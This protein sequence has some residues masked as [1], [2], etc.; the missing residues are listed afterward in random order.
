MADS[1]A[2]NLD[3]ILSGGE[4]VEWNIVDN[5]LFFKLI[6]K[7]LLESFLLI[8]YYSIENY[9]SDWAAA[10]LAIGTLNGEQLT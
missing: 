1:G 3:D 8:I 2:I 7:T 4:M 5:K 10:S 6:K 9:N